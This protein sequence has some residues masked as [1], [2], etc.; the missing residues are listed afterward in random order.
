MTETFGNVL[1]EAMASGLA[2]AG[3]DY[4]AARQF[5]RDRDNGLVVPCDQPDAL[6]AA[7]VE[8]AT[9]PDL[10]ARVRKAARHGFEK[11]SWSHVIGRFEGDLLAAANLGG[12]V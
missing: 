7:A 9:D 8:L 1:T 12:T 5:V 11:Q 4:A 6:V 10:R 2:V 3:F